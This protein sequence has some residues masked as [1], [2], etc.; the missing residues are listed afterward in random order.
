MGFYARRIGFTLSVLLGLTL[1]S[2]CSGSDAPSGKGDQAQ[3]GEGSLAGDG[4]G[5]EDE[6][7]SGSAGE[8]GSASEG[9]SADEGG[10]AGEGGNAGDG[11][12]GE[13]GGGDGGR[14]PEAETS[15]WSLT[16]HA[17]PLSV[18]YTLETASRVVMDMPLSG[19]T[20]ST[21][22]EDGTEFELTVPGDALI[23]PETISMTPV[24][25]TEQPFGD[26]PVWGVQ[27]LPDGLA[28]NQPVKLVITPVASE[29]PPVEQQL[30]FGWSGENNE[31]ILASPDSKD[32]KLSLLLL[33]FSSY[34]Y[35]TAK[36]GVSASL[37][38]VRVRIGG[39][40]EARLQ[41]AAAE[42]LMKDRQAALLGSAEMGMVSWPE[43]ERLLAEYNE[44]VVKVRI[45]A[46][47]SSCAAGRLALETLLL[48]ERQNELLGMKV[49]ASTTLSQLMLTVS[50]VCLEEEWLL[51][52]DEHIV[53]R[54]I[55]VYLGMERQWELLGGQM[56]GAAWQAKALDYI[57]KCHKFRLEVTSEGS[58]VSD[59]WIFNEDVDGDIS[60][61]ATG[62]G[63][64]IM[65]TGSLLS[66]GYSM[67]YTKCARVSNVMQVDSTFL[68]NEL[69]W[70]LKTD[71]L[72]P[73]KGEVADF[74][75]TYFPVAGFGSTHVWNDT[76]GKPPAPPLTVGQF[77][78]G[79]IYGIVTSE[80][81]DHFSDAGWHLRDWQVLNNGGA[82][83]ATKTFNLVVNDGGIVYSAPSSYVLVHTPG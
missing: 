30:P 43:L 78:W 33:H 16:P 11:A 1:G 71:P 7:G 76:C 3:G 79:S 63:S 23:S 10:S 2:A 24:K 46:A 69:A 26:G 82:T 81:P 50:D 40:A 28:F 47:A 51:C 17:S 37:A 58:S 31:V 35:A 38:G 6:P 62:L 21:T 56:S 48:F 12:A 19:G 49:T 32:S 68:V 13:G 44:E 41:S 34:A 72:Q 4:A 39:S 77:N 75:M 66:V 70:N 8:G 57:S 36:S 42:L 59:Q 27:L 53:Q 5:G 83:L 61:A 80:N 14:P 67:K 73:G 15:L 55:P 9:G 54:I 25:L 64:P 22:A 18:V 45:A 60:L 29:I 20:L 52:R 65:G 74:V